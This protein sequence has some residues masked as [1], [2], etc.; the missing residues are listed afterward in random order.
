MALSAVFS[1]S[2][3]A[4]Q[5]STANST[6]ST[7]IVAPI[8]ITKVTDMSFGS[9]ATGSAG[10]LVL[11][12][13]GLR[14]PTGGVKVTATT[15]TVAAAEFKVTG[16][17]SYGYDVTLPASLI[18]STTT[19]GTGTVKDMT[20]N[21]FTSS[22]TDNKGSLTSGSQNFTVGATLNVVAAQ[23]IGTYANAAGFSVT[24]N[25]N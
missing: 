3:F 16:E 25:Y 19:A 23:A 4:Q 14:N 15:G 17:G 18:L 7:T 10:T 24:V 13:A 21:T 12:P 8:A 5:N 20:V 2:A 9:F 6:A 11:S 1:T 22:L